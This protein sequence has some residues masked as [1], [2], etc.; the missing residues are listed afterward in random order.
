MTACS[1]ASNCGFQVETEAITDLG[2]A[3]CQA[4]SMRLTRHEPI[5]PAAQRGI[6]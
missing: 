4:G 5:H 6:M 1:G 3:L 2:Y